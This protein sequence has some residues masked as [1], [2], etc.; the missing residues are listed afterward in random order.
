M[1]LPLEEIRLTDSD[2]TV[3]T[4]C[5]NCNKTGLGLKAANYYS[6]A[7][8]KKQWARKPKCDNCHTDMQFKYEVET[9]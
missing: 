3:F 2:R 4:V 8:S 1:R 7:Y 5:P 9:E 6:M